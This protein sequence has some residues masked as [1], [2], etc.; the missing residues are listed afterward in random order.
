[1]DVLRIT[2]RRSGHL[3]RERTVRKASNFEAAKSED[4]IIFNS[5]QAA[6]PSIR[7]PI[8]TL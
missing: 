2:N 7:V 6:R 3:P 1:M 8:F 4:G 5:L